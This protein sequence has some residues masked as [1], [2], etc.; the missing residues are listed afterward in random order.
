MNQENEICY[1]YIQ[2]KKTQQTSFFDPLR[3]AKIMKSQKRNQRDDGIVLIEVN[4][5]RG[6]VDGL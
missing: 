3:R 6:L 1:L 2:L 4:G 5:F